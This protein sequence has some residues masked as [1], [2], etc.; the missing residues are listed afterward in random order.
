MRIEI[1]VDNEDPQIF[2]LNKPKIVIG[3]HESC[4][5]ILSREGISRKHLVIL[6]E[7]DNFFAV[8]Q[9]SMNGSYINEERLVPGRR[10]EFTSFFPVRLGDNVLITLLSDEEASDLGFSELNETPAKPAPT[11]PD[12]NDEATRTISLRDLQNVKTESLVRK[13]Q[14]TVTRRRASVSKPPPK[15]ADDKHRMLWVKFLAGSI[16]AGAVYLN[17]FQKEELSEV[18][19]KP[20]QPKSVTVKKEIPPEP[21]SELVDK[22]DLT[23]AQKFPEYKQF[24]SCSTDAEKYLCDLMPAGTQVVQTGTMVHVFIDGTKYYEQAESMLPAYKFQNGP[25]P[26]SEQIEKY[27]NNIK[28]A[29]MM[30]FIRDGF[31]KDIDYQ[32]LGQVN[33]TL[34]LS[35]HA[36]DGAVAY[37]AGAFVPASLNKMISLFR[38]DQFEL[39]RK[40]GADALYYLREY[41]VFY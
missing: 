9:G 25:R 15:K 7:D 17:I 1:L 32:K 41:G 30:L 31:P 27:Q 10:T 6:Q 3:S 24:V 26:E 20:A 16:L 37:Y 40:Y 14:E 22:M 18:P 28:Y 38:H 34:V 29:A 4:D 36:S 13:R 39:M 19:V 35:R 12:R 5:V 21:K 33:F 2:P 8:D 23:D 11:A